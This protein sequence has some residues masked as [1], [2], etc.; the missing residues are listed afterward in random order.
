MKKFLLS[1]SA[2][3]LSALPVFA[4]T[5]EAGTAD[6]PKYYV[7]KAGRGIPYVTYTAEAKNANG[8]QTT[9]YRANE[10]SEAAIWA[11][12]PG[13]EENTVNIYNYTTKDDENKAYMFSFI[14][15]NGSEF[16]GETGAVASTGD[17]QDVYCKDNKNGTYGLALNSE[18][19]KFND[20]YYALDAT[21]GTS[22]FMGNWLNQNDG[23]TQWKFY[24]ADVSNGVEAALAGVQQAINEEA[25]QAMVNEYIG[26]FQNYK[27]AVSYVAAELQA[28]IDALNNL[29]YSDDYSTQITNIWGTYTTNANNKLNTMFAG[30][31]VALN[32]IRKHNAG[33]ASYLGINDDDNGYWGVASYDTNEKAAFVLEST[34]YDNA[35]SYYLYNAATETYFGA[36]LTPVSSKDDA[37]SIR[38]VLQTGHDSGGANPIVGLNV[39]ANGGGTNNAL[40]LNNQNPPRAS[41]WKKNGNDSDGSIWSV[42]DIMNEAVN[43]VTSVL[44]PYVANVPADVASILN[45]AIEEANALEY[46]Q[47]VVAKATGIR[48]KAINDAD[49]L[50][51]AGLN[52]NLYT[53]KNLRRAANAKGRNPYIAV[54]MTSDKYLPVASA[55]DFN[56]QFTFNSVGEGGYTLYNP[57]TET[58]IGQKTSTTETEGANGETTTKTTTWFGPVEDANESVKV[59]PKLNTYG[60]YYGVAFPFNADQTGDGF[61]ED[62]GADPTGGSLTPWDI[63]D[64]GSI[65]ALA[66]VD[67]QGKLDEAFNSVK[68]AL[69]PY[70]P[71][72]P[73]EVADILQK[74]IDDASKLEYNANLAAN[75]EELRENAIADGNTTLESL[76]N[77]KVYT[78]KN[79]RRASGGKNAYIA[80]NTASDNYLPVATMADF[81]A[82]FT[83]ESVADGGYKL[84]NDNSGTYISST[85][86][87]NSQYLQTPDEAS[88]LTVYPILHSYS[89]FSGVAFPFSDKHTGNGFN[90]NNNDDPN[91]GPLTAW[92]IDDDGSIWALAEFDV[93][94]AIDN[95]VNSVKTALEPYIPNVPSEVADILQKAIDDAKDLEYN[96]NLAAN[97]EALR[98]DALA[99]GNAK[100]KVALTNKNWALKTL[101]NGYV[102]ANGSTDAF[103]VGGTDSAENDY[104]FMPTEDGGFI[105]YS[106]SAKKYLG[107]VGSET[108]MTLV[109]EQANAQKVYPVLNHNGNYYGISFPLTNAS[110]PSTQGLNTNA[111]G[112]YSYQIDDAG[113]IFAVSLKANTVAIEEVENAEVGVE[114]VYDLQGRR[115]NGNAKGLLIVNGKKIYRK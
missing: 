11:V 18:S 39:L 69:E 16:T 7:I 34:T 60:G 4:D 113:S 97:A 80:V 83:F 59:Y 17:A 72:V 65:W 51:A 77:D 92:N 5:L 82:Q 61:N 86:N 26:Y 68:T 1:L 55:D 43:S 64:G 100:L 56:A 23:G 63:N 85:Q 8:A 13:T 40:N 105:L 54:N 94:A 52:G 9:L 27:N 57:T 31:V 107:P 20:G 50:L 67:V 37:C 48:T 49:A 99:D 90:E 35:A 19:G 24:S 36:S 112:M 3:A 28:G 109:S 42:V 110:A 58:Y 103:T 95:A 89:D 10:L 81:N 114:V 2:L 102:K 53:L 87:A 98:T 29:E 73:A 91:G 104:D 101:R 46:S 70:I 71:N 22:E 84:Y 74:A 30:K 12:V 62:E 41:L 88:A 66:K 6:A 76:L 25:M 21:G 106:P 14:T 75:A 78:L 32:N 15:T 108:K 47:G 79:L 93:Q 111:A 45:A 44:E 96:A 115:V 33:I 38:L